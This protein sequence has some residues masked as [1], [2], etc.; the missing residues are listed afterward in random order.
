MPRFP[1]SRYTHQRPHRR[2]A[3]ALL[4]PTFGVL[5]FAL[6]GLASADGEYV[7]LYPKTIKDLR[8]ILDTLESAIAEPKPDEHRPIVV[9]LHGAQ[10][11]RF[12][13][14]NY[15]HNKAIVD[16]A[17]KLA[18]YDVIDVK[19]CETWMRQNDYDVDDLFP[20]VNTVPYG[21]GELKRLVEEE[22]YREFSVQL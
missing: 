4:A 1:T 13:R 12:V 22:D 2:G 8:T 3:S 19:I 21:A 11:H 10:A 15:P 17:A 18:A 5:L 6:A 14:D 9:M 7:D 20:F 16:Q